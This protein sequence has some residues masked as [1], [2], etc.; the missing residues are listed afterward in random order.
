M[1][2]IRI[3]TERVGFAPG[4][5]RALDFNKWSMIASGRSFNIFEFIFFNRKLACEVSTPL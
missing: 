3:F 5:D 1:I 4:V 2:C